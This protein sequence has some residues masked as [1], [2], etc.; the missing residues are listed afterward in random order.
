MSD[1]EHKDVSI[2]IIR[3]D[4]FLSATRV[5]GRAAAANTDL[6]PN[7]PLQEYDLILQEARESRNLPELC[8]R[9][10]QTEADPARPEIRQTRHRNTR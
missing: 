10:R 5:R 3:F 4:L 7:A 2:M 8:T 1:E 6:I 9:V